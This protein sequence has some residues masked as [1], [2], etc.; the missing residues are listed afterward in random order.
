MPSLTRVLSPEAI[1]VSNA[2][3]TTALDSGNAITRKRANSDDAH[4]STVAAKRTKD[5]SHAASAVS[6]TGNINLA[7]SNQSASGASA[8][9]TTEKATLSVSFSGGGNGPSTVNTSAQRADDSNATQQFS[10]NAT[11]TAND[12]DDDSSTTSEED[13]TV[14]PHPLNSQYSNVLS[15]FMATPF[16]MNAMRSLHVLKEGKS[17]DPL[18]RLMHLQPTQI[19]FRH[20]SY[21]L[22]QPHQPRQIGEVSRPLTLP[23]V[24]QKKFVHI[25]KDKMNERKER[26]RS[27]REGRKETDGQNGNGGSSG[28]DVGAMNGGDMSGKAATTSRQTQSTGGYEHGAL[29]QCRTNPQQQQHSNNVYS[30][31]LQQ[32]QMARNKM[33]QLYALQMNDAQRTH[34]NSASRMGMG[35]ALYPQ[36]FSMMNTAGQQ[37][38]QPRV[39]TAGQQQY[40]VDHMWMQQP[41]G[42]GVGTTVHA[43]QPAASTTQ[44]KRRQSQKKPVPQQYPP[45]PQQMSVRPAPVI[46]VAVASK[47]FAVTKTNLESIAKLPVA[48]SFTNGNETSKSAAQSA[49]AKWL[50]DGK[51]AAR[52]KRQMKAKA[53]P[54]KPKP[55]SSLGSS[56]DD[57][58]SARPSALLIS[59]DAVPSNLPAGWTTETYERQTG[60]SAGSKDTYFYSPVK[61]LKFRSAK[62]VKLFIGLLY[63]VEVGG[64]ETK[65]MAL[66]KKRGYRL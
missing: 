28:M 65:A 10:N 16:D 51:K 1:P 34:N 60:K 21:Q 12:H 33:M 27:A 64:D 18:D 42:H 47:P 59:Y 15:W 37:H 3:Q 26:G 50:A 6:T 53:T 7:P 45:Y 11:M 55:K 35:M 46:K 17:T 2:G 23:I 30:F 61:K 49:A 63:E 8:E 20:P 40:L 5:T 43:K 4:H 39:N 54:S 13:E 31:N 38:Q 44:T 56:P 57:D 29:Q 14:I 19:Q 36:Q 41:R 22:Q 66:F 32:Q 24:H 58:K 62:S 48:F 25:I 9:A 52:D